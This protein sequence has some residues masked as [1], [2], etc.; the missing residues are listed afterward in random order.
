MEKQKKFS[1]Q[2]SQK[3]HTVENPLEQKLDGFQ[4]KVG[5]LFDSLQC[6]ISKLAQQLDHQGE[7]NPEEVCLSDTMVEDHCQQQL[8]K[9]LVENIESSGI[10]AAICLCEK[11]EVIPLL[12][13]EEAVEEH[14]DHNLSLPP[15]GSVY[16]LPSLAPQ[17]Q[18][19]S[20]TAKAHAT[21]NP[22]P[23]ALYSEPLHTLL[24][25]ATQFTPEAPAPKAESIPSA[26][27]V[28]YFKKLVTFVQTFATTSKK[29]AAAHTA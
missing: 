26:L 3:I 25:P 7:E 4:S 5:Q 17:S 1:A 29:M 27:P 13:T 22:L 28:Q 10:G 18:P 8:Q 14:Q 2:L 24:I 23:G 20:P 15:T 21:N 19:K 6:S 12:L 16:I 9:G 11:N